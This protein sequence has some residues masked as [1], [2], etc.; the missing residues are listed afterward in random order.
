[1]IKR[2]AWSLEEF[3]ELSAEALERKQLPAG[4]FALICEQ[5]TPFK[6]QYRLD[7]LVR[8]PSSSYI[9]SS[10]PIAPSPTRSLTYRESPPLP[11]R[12][13][14]SDGIMRGYT[15]PNAPPRVLDTYYTDELDMELLDHD[16]G[17]NMKVFIEEEREFNKE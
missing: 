6:A 14:D 5:I 10:P 9:P 13:Y 17:V 4:P 11:N 12:V 7:N 15:Q 2:E 8:T 3:R 16:Y 1:M